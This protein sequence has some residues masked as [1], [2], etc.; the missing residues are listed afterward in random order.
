MLELFFQC[1]ENS[2]LINNQPYPYHIR[3]IDISTMHMV[4]TLDFYIIRHQKRTHKC[5]SLGRCVKKGVVVNKQD[6]LTK[7]LANFT[8]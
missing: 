3:S 7:L 5:L 1:P 6:N 4:G 8:S 2:S